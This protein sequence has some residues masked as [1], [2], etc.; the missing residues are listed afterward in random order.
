MG[1][2][3]P[4]RD[5]G[6]AGDYVKAMWAMLQ[7]D[8]PDD[9]VVATGETHTVEEF[10][11]NAFAHAGIDDWQRYVKQDPRFLRPAEVDLLVGDASKAPRGARLAARGGLRRARE[12]DGRP[13]PEDRAHQARQDLTAMATGREHSPEDRYDSAT[14]ARTVAKATMDETASP[15]EPSAVSA[16]S[17][18]ASLATRAGVDTITPVGRQRGM[19]RTVLRVAGVPAGSGRV[20]P[21]R[22]GA[23]GP[24][25]SPRRRGAPGR[26]G[27]PTPTPRA[28]TGERAGL[29]PVARGDR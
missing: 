13:R 25:R 19:K 21:P 3:H 5:W 26:A 1:D 9:Y 28:A 24:D 12:A 27:G 7:Q 18:L 6:Y 8:E 22:H 11:S 2:L 23:G 15:L 20:Q 4:K 29:R 16:D 17:V 10:V 14:E